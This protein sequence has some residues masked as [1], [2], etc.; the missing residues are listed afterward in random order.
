MSNDMRIDLNFVDHPKVKRLIRKAGY[1]AFYGLLRIFSIAGKMYTKGVFKDCD[2]DDIE[3]FADWHGKPGLFVEVMV[4]VGLLVQGTDGYYI[5]HD[6]DQHQPWI[7]HSDVRSE[8]ARK[9]IETR[10]GKREN[11]QINASN[12]VSIR[13]EY[14]TNTESNTP[15]PSPSPSPSPSPYPSPNHE[16]KDK[17][18]DNKIISSQVKPDS[19]FLSQARE[20]ASLL[21]SESRKSDPKLRIGKDK[22]TIE[23]WAKDI[24]KLLRID[25]RSFDDVKSV[26][27]W[28]KT[29]GN[30]WLPNIL[31]GKKLREKFPTMH[32]QMISKPMGNYRQEKRFKP[33]C[34]PD[35]NPNE[36]NHID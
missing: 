22:Q 13:N 10:W 34:T 25:Q 17:C 29:I 14:G 20:L 30:F 6:W 27:L 9:A 1:E 2:T 24:E 32:S 4:E 8:Q 28:C 12:T 18:E 31:S 11:S 21:L 23:Q 33:E 15:Y 3:D 35:A 5:I 36:F 16:E 19:I 7:Y 26:I